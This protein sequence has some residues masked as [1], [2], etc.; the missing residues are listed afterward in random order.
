[1]L[2]RRANELMH[3]TSTKIEPV[4]M[5]NWRQH[6]E[7]VLALVFPAI[8]E[9]QLKLS[10]KT[11]KYYDDK[12]QKLLTADLPK[13]M[14]V[15]IRDPQYTKGNP[16]PRAAQRNI[17]PYWIVRRAF[18]G[19]YIVKDATGAERRVP[20]D[21]LIFTRTEKRASTTAVEKTKDVYEVAK[22]LNDR[23]N[24]KQRRREWLIRWRGYGEAD[25]TWEPREHIH[26][27]KTITDYDKKKKLA[28]VR[29]VLA[30]HSGELIE[31]D[32][33]TTISRP[34]GQRLSIIDQ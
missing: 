19:P 14:E 3:Y 12:R 20:I 33:R 34:E 16:R 4:T 18:N 10:A 21:Q 31:L 17:G 27:T 11:R 28:R 1:M 26:N 22:V 24:R 6:Q 5:D 15:M 2:N 13:G 30:R 32:L 9:R 23:Y 29:S 7:E 8:Q 25:D